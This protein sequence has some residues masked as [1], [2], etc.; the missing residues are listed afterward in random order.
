MTLR[1]P[2]ESVEWVESTVTLD[3]VVKTTGVEF[4][5]TPDNNN[6]PL[7]WGAAVVRGGKTG[8]LVSGR[9]PGTY[10]VYARITDATD[11]VVRNVGIFVIY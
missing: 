9:T 11:Q 2:A 4:S 6:R 8:F 10:R 7:V 3:G 5:I 1:I